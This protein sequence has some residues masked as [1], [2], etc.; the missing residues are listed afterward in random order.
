MYKSSYAYIISE[1]GV[2]KAEFLEGHLEFGDI[3][4]GVLQHLEPLED[5]A[6]Q[7]LHSS[8]VQSIPIQD[9]ALQ[10]LHLRCFHVLYKE[11]DWGLGDVV[12]GQIQALEQRVGLGQDAEEQLQAVVRE[13]AV[14]EGESAEARVHAQRFEQLHY[15]VLLIEEGVVKGD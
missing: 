3:A 1:L 11:L 13:A 12:L 10:S 6:G 9:K 4:V 7:L 8:I 14:G 5:A 2:G 15:L